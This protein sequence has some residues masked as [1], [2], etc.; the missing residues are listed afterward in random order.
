MESRLS[1]YY[2]DHTSPYGYGDSS[3]LMKGFNINRKKKIKESKV[4]EYLSGEETYTLHR[5][6]RKKIK[7]AKIVAFA[8]DNI[9]QTDLCD[10]QKYSQYN[11]KNTFLLFV[12]DV[13][14]RQLWVEPLLNKKPTT[15]ASAF[16]A[17]MEGSC[18]IP[19]FVH[20]DKGTEFI[21]KSFKQMLDEFNIRLYHTYSPNKAAMVERVQ[22]TMK[23]RLFKYF[24][25]KRSYR[26]I[27]VLPDFVKAYNNTSHRMINTTP[28]NQYKSFDD[29]T[30]FHRTDQSRPKAMLRVGD[31]IR[32]SR[33]DDD[34]GRFRKGYLAGWTNEIFR[35][36]RVNTNGSVV[37]YY[38]VDLN[39]EVI[40]GCFYHEEIQKIEFSPETHSFKVDE[41]LGER[42]RG[43]RKEYLVSWLGYGPSFNSYIKASAIERLA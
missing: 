29:E 21:G 7:S 8:P 24:S 28:N 10:M 32:I 26:Y 39:N 5:N 18:R 16:R 37:R 27:E 25:Y 17:I 1:K 23:S 33:R 38:I 11:D 9:W 41:I 43:K 3:K 42:G 34:R 19:A 2:Y 40:E 35:I 6:V 13:Y 14:T 36:A 20:S 22:R 12:M 31:Y 4:K 30:I 15:V